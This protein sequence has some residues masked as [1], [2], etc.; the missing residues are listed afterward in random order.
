MVNQETRHEPVTG[1][2][3]RGVVMV[4]DDLE[5]IP[6]CGVPAG[7]RVRWYEEGDAA[8]WMRIHEASEGYGAL[9]ATL[10]AEQFGDDPEVLRQRIAFVCDPD[11]VPV[12]TNAAWFG[13][14][15][16]ETWGRVHWVATS[17][18]A[19][20]KGLS[21]PLMTAVMERMKALGH[22]RAYLTTNTIRVRAIALYA[23]FGFKAFWET[24]EEE[25][26]WGEV[27][28]VMEGMGRDL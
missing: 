10:F 25:R 19:Q 9:K 14:R 7:Y 27:K 2:E 23:G 13:E 6:V 28:K 8:H 11:G 22:T 17:R 12:A 20:G 18:R 4:R 24:A 3:G 5:A 26:A 1:V 21:K 16:G 15:E